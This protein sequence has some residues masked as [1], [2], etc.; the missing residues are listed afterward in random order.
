MKQNVKPPQRYHRFCCW[1]VTNTQSSQFF[2]LETDKLTLTAA[3][4]GKNS[5]SH[6][7]DDQLLVMAWSKCILK[8]KSSRMIKD[9][10]I[11]SCTESTGMG[12][13]KHL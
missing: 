3:D 4:H 10:C 7:Y 13:Q 5:V 1:V 6:L 8:S 12:A 11:D 9:T 2:K